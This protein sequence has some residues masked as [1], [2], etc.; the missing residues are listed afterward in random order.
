[1]SLLNTKTNLK[2]VYW[3]LACAWTLLIFYFSSQSETTALGL[4]NFIPFS[5]KLVH[6]AVFGI[7]A[8]FL[9]LATE[10]PRLAVILT[11]L[12]G[13]ADEFHQHFVPGRQTDIFDWLADTLGAIVVVLIMEKWLKPKISQRA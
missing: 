12:Y 4:L 2:F 1:M 8:L 9:Y 6:A 3:A 10:N 11:A 5:D 7:L 13:M